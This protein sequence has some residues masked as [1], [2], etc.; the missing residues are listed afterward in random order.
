MRGNDLVSEISLRLSAVRNLTCSVQATSSSALALYPAGAGG[1]FFPPHPANT[2]LVHDG[3]IH[4][5]RWSTL[6]SSLCHVVI[7]TVRGG[8]WM[9]KERRGEDVWCQSSD[10]TLY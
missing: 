3:F 5:D 10:T 4:G 6:V 1:V 8:G 2:I 9:E 7:D